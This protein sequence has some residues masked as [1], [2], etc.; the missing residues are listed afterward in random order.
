MAERVPLSLDEL[1][2]LEHYLCRIRNRRRL[3][4]GSDATIVSGAPV[5]MIGKM[6]D[7]R[8]LTSSKGSARLPHFRRKP[9]QTRWAGPNST[10]RSSLQVS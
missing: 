8:S 7:R 6:L 4:G 5:T 1:L 3:F 10:C 2:E 9:S